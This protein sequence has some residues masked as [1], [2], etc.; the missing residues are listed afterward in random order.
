MSANPAWLTQ[1]V[2]DIAD[3][4]AAGLHWSVP[5][6]AGRNTVKAVARTAAGAEL[7]DELAFDY[8]TEP[9]GKPTGL[10]LTEV[11]R[12]G[13][14]VL[15]EAAALDKDGAVCLDAAHVVRFGVVGEGTLLDNLGTPDG[16]RVVQLA[17]GR[18]RIRVVL[19]GRKV[20]AAVTSPGLTSAFVTVDA[21]PPG[22]AAS[23]PAAKPVAVSW[24]SPSVVI[25]VAGLDRERIRRAA[26]SAL[27]LP[28]LTITAHRPPLPDGD[29]HDFHSRLRPP[30]PA[31]AQSASTRL[32]TAPAAQTPRRRRPRPTCRPPGRRPSP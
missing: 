19:D 9:W 12:N 5:L 18:A 3:Y 7:S 25:D 16:S 30:L 6:V 26:D 28:P 22:A 10:A 8:R 24:A 1:L 4:P 23:P 21:A 20:V 32:P 13:A 2:R 14:T 11:S 15:V 27:G 17:N 29:A 31:A